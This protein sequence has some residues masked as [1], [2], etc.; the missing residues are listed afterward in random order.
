MAGNGDGACRTLGQCLALMSLSTSDHELKLNHC[1]KEKCPQVAY[2]IPVEIA[3]AESAA[4]A[5]AAAAVTAVASSLALNLFPSSLLRDCR[6][7][8]LRRGPCHLSSLSK[9]F[10][11]PRVQFF[12]LICGSATGRTPH[13]CVL[14]PV[15]YVVLASRHPGYVE[16]SKQ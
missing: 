12:N 11:T 13:T 15:L 5:T 16:R 14:S 3:L 6:S 10:L 8:Q 2:V 4:A 9:S 7:T 1:S